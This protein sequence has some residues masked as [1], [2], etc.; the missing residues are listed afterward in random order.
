METPEPMGR[1]DAAAAVN[2][3]EGGVLGWDAGQWRAVEDGVRRLRQQI[4]TASKAGERGKVRT[5]QKLMP[6]SR[7]NALLGVRRGA[8]VNAGRK[9]AGVDGRIV[10]TGWGKAEL[11]TWLQQGAAAWRPRPVRR[12][13]LPESGGTAARARDSRDRR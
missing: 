2:G 5:L 10:L 4:V 9:T 11:A 7:A 13:F 3:P 12:V 6:G 1:L 8:E